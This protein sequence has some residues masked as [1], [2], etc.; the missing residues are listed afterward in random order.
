V[1]LSVALLSSTALGQSIRPQVPV[2][3]GLPGTSVSVLWLVETPDVPLLGYSLDLNL[4][5]PPAPGTQGTATVDAGATNFFQVQNLFTA[6][7]A[8]L[9]PIFSIIES[10]G[11][12]G[13]FVNAIATDL[14]TATPV[15]GVND[16]L[17]QVVFTISPDAV[18]EFVFGLGPLTA[19]SDAEGFPVPFTGES[20][21]L[22]VVPSPGVPFVGM[23]FAGIAL[24]GR[25]RPRSAP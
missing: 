16:V 7:G 8:T 13:V 12:G 25:R 6:A 10:D 11:A 2:L 5:S 21:T 22:R 9:D 20:F 14:S 3:E 23:M 24:V 19:L 1:V 18:G 4:Q 17:A 15:P